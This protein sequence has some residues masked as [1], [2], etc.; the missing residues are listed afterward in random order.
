MFMAEQLVAQDHVITS[1]LESIMR[2]KF[3]KIHQKYADN[4]HNAAT[5]SPPS[6]EEGFLC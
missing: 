3:S 4:F 6:Q 2:A 5:Q 1:F